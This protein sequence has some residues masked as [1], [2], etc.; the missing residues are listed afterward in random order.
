[1]GDWLKGRECNQAILPVWLYAPLWSPRHQPTL[2]SPS[3]RKAVITIGCAE[4]KAINSWLW[5][6]DRESQG[7]HYGAHHHPA[8]CIHPL[9]HMHIRGSSTWTGSHSISQSSLVLHCIRSLYGAIFYPF[10]RHGLWQ[11][12]W[13]TRAERGNHWQASCR[14]NLSPNSHQVPLHDFFLPQIKT[15]SVMTPIRTVGRTETV[16]RVWFKY[17]QFFQCSQAI[18][19]AI[20][21]QGDLVVTQVSAQET[22][23]RE[24]EVST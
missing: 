3:G 23:G 10:L 13:D 8:A 6:A 14:V 19:G 22:W 20:S 21:Q 11:Q 24:D 12:R 15:A 16:K 1:M 2:V 17:S 9:G 4:V 18:E 7:D 5:G